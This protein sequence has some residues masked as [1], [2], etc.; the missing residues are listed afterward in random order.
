MSGDPAARLLD[1]TRL[2]SRVGLGPLTGVDRIEAAY[3]TALRAEPVPLYLLCRTGYGFLLLPGAAGEFLLAG[4]SAPD[5]LPRASW[6][7][8]LRGR[9]GP[10]ARLEAGLRARALARAPHARL[11]ALIARHLPRPAIYLNVGQTTVRPDT[12]ARLKRVP[13]LRITVMVHDTIPLDFPQF[14]R[15]GEPERFRAALAATLA[16]ADLVICN[17]AATGADVR[18]H[19]QGRLPRLLTAYPGIELAAPDPAQIPADLDLMP[20]YFV[21]LGTIEPRKN[22][23]LLLDV[24]EDI[25]RDMPEAQAPRLLIL[26]RR[27]W[28]NE[29]VFARL[30][31][32]PYMGRV[33]HELPGLP[34]AAVSALLAGA[35]G[36]LMPSRAEGFGLPY[37]EAAAAGIAVIA[38]PLPAAKEILGQAGIYADPDDRY[39]WRGEILRLAHEK[40]PV[41]DN[42]WA[43]TIPTWA[44]HFKTV[45]TAT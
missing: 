5:T 20:Q 1:I 41:Q 37:L 39:L 15:A 34:D 33:V 3:L 13:G 19:A 23:A 4:L 7:D 9:G 26:G 36:L 10:R 24:W 29:E 2:V 28:R 22:H 25:L 11:T 42:P 35:R 31:S 30:D 17:S 14:A 43:V 32:A 38:A 8:R 45:L 6:F 18:R 40:T 27:G 21:T 44:A 12:L 16:H